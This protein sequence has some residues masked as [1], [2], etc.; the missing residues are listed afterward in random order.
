MTDF[1]FIIECLLK[2]IVQM[3]V[4][5][6]ACNLGYSGCKGRRISSSIALAKAVERPCL[7]TRKKGWGLE[8]KW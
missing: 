2:S 5:V 8:L 4:M 1:C 7:K 6:H 3:A